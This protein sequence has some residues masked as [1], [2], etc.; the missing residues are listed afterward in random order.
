MHGSLVPVCMTP[1]VRQLGKSVHVNR[2]DQFSRRYFAADWE[3]P[4]VIGP[5]DFRNDVSIAYNAVG[6]LSLARQTP[7]RN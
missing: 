6:A 4:Y 3:W 1:V 7:I 2:L 5:D